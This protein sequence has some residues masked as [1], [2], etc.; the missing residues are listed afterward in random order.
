MKFVLRGER[1]V[2]VVISE[3]ANGYEE[4]LSAWQDIQSA[5]AILRKVGYVSIG[6]ITVSLRK[7][8]DGREE[9]VGFDRI[10]GDDEFRIP[11]PKGGEIL[12]IL[13]IKDVSVFLKAG[14]Y[15]R[16]V[17]S[18]YEEQKRKTLSQVN[19]RLK[20]L[21]DFAYENGLNPKEIILYYDTKTKQEVSLEELV[22]GGLEKLGA[23]NLRDIEVVDRNISTAKR[24]IEKHLENIQSQTASPNL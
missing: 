23:Y 1:D 15:A 8:D 7:Y 16:L 4:L 13:E 12:E 11:I 9:L 14:E 22:N 5:L 18:A 19:E 21:Y 17:P 24:I 6:D 20:S 10:K 2:K 3:G